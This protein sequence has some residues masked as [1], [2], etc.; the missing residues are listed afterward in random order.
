MLS[1]DNS[2]LNRA[3]QAREETEK[4]Q[5]EENVQIAYMAALSNGNG[6]ITQQLFETELTKTLGEK[7]IAYKIVDN[8]TTWEISIIGKNVT[9][10]IVKPSNLVKNVEVTDLQRLTNYFLPGTRATYD[11]SE[12]GESF[13]H[14]DGEN[15]ADE[16]LIH[17]IGPGEG[18]KSIIIQYN[19]AYYK[20]SF[21]ESFVFTR[22][23]PYT[24]STE[25]SDEELEALI[26]RDGTYMYDEDDVENLNHIL[27]YNY[28]NKI[29]KLTYKVGKADETLV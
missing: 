21:N 25:I 13:K 10:T 1:G 6:V 4:K 16:R 24:Y 17:T 22:V 7:D 15:M 12:D 20:I 29:Y 2:I 18:E 23:E 14:I 26:R 27:Y 19:N 5:F 11:V 28:N 8:D 9:K 3:G